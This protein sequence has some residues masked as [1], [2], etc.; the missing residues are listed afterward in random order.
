MQVLGWSM[1]F[2]GYIFLERSWTKD[3]NTLKVELYIVVFNTLHPFLQYLPFNIFLGSITAV[4]FQKSLW[5]S[6]ALLVSPLGRRNSFYTS[7]AFGSSRVCCFNRAT[8]ST[9]CFD[10]SHQGFYSSNT[11][12]VH[13]S[14]LLIY[15]IPF[16]KQ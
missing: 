12:L 8:C 13:L 1:W 15:C 2:S 6:P 7:K 5:L 14:F 16:S 9:E 11:V 3:E 10:T 4:R